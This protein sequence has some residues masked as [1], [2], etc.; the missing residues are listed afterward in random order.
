MSKKPSMKELIRVL[1]R[2]NAFEILSELKNMHNEEGKNAVLVALDAKQYDKVEI[3]LSPVKKPDKDEYVIFFNPF[4][5]AVTRGTKPLK[6]PAVPEKMQ[7]LSDYTGIIDTKDAFY[8]FYSIYS[9]V[10]CMRNKEAREFFEEITTHVPHDLFTKIRV[11]DIANS[12]ENRKSNVYTAEDIIKYYPLP[13]I[14]FITELF[15]KGIN[16]RTTFNKDTGGTI[17]INT[18]ELSDRNLVVIEFLT[19]YNLAATR[20]EDLVININ[21]LKNPTL[22]DIEEQLARISNIFVKQTPKYDKIDIDEYYERLRSLMSRYEVKLPVDPDRE[23]K[24]KLCQ[25]YNRKLTLSDDGTFFYIH[26]GVKE[27]VEN[28]KE[29]KL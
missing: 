16:A 1:D 10:E 7:Y 29:I 14:S 8:D 28:G 21:L 22:R 25:K 13:F 4:T 6:W 5:N 19:K 26:P 12:V 15:N 3:M 2:E 18:K 17:I 23:G 11:H 27:R 9:Y 20:G 24:I